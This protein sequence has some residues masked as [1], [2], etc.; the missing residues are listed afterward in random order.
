[1]ASTVF[2]FAVYAHRWRSENNIQELVFS[3]TVT[4]RF[5]PGLSCR[6]LYPRAISTAPMSP[7]VSA[8]GL[9]LLPEA[10]LV[11]ETHPCQSRSAL[12]TPQSP[13]CPSE[14]SQHPASPAAASGAAAPAEAGL[15]GGQLS[16]HNLQVS[17]SQRGGCWSQWVFYTKSLYLP[18][19]QESVLCA[20]GRPVS[21]S[22]ISPR[23]E[24][25]WPVTLGSV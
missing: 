9:A 11:V 17:A 16:C 3:S 24:V 14:S 13:R 12:K 8:L 22:S 25:G 2:L 10:P 7:I 5:Q 15:F 1:M 20:P 23:A 18:R 19:Q 21:L 4:P 6:S